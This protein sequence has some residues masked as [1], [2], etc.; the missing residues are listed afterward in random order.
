MGRPKSWVFLSGM[1]LLVVRLA[2]ASTVGILK[3]MTVQE[4]I[5]QLSAVEDPTRKVIVAGYEEPRLLG[6]FRPGHVIIWGAD[7]LAA[8]EKR[9]GTRFF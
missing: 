4:L 9:T 6:R 2:D 5:D 1:G 8:A 7:D 3:G